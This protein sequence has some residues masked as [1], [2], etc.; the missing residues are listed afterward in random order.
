MSTPLQQL[1]PVNQYRAERAHVYQS[2]EALRWTLRQ[3]GQRFADAGALVIIGRRKFV[4]PERFD[5]V[6]F[7]L[8]QKA[9]T[10]A[11]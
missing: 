9:A 2:D 8:G 6:A 3:H 5:K 11:H 10:A 7:E 1:I 4:H